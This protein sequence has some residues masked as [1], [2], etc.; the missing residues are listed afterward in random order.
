MRTTGKW[1]HPLQVP[2]FDVACGDGRTIDLD[3]LHGRV[4]RIVALSGDAATA[5]VPQ[6][7]TGVTTII[8]TKK[9]T[10]RPEP[11]MC[12]A[13]EPETWTA[14]AVLSGVSSDALA[15]EHVLVDQNAWLR[16]VWRPG[17]PDNWMDVR[18]LTATVRDVTAHPI[19]AGATG[20][21]LHRQ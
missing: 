10:A 15:G 9:R 21:H 2:Q 3:D 6:I 1:S 7:A 16:A 20:V 4:L 11:A 8:L 18:E 13:S 19:A 12:V 17:D 14:F 5:P